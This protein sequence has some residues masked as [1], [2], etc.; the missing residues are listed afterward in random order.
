MAAVSKYVMVMGRTSP[1][2]E[3]SSLRI[4]ALTSCPYGIWVLFRMLLIRFCTFL[5]L[6]TDCCCR[7]DPFFFAYR[8]PI[9]RIKT[10]FN[11]HLPCIDYLL[12][13]LLSLYCIRRFSFRNQPHIEVLVSYFSKKTRTCLV[14]EFCHQFTR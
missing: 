7:A 10:L 9:E 3:L 5:V 6:E 14:L 8:I 2:L 12:D 13:T 1:L 11:C 4:L